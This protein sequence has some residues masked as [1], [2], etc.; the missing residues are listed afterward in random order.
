[1]VFAV[2]LSGMCINDDVVTCHLFPASMLTV[3]G[4]TWL[5]LE[6]VNNCNNEDYRT[7]EKQYAEL[8]NGKGEIMN[9]L[10]TAMNSKTETAQLLA[11]EL[12]DFTG[13]DNPAT[14]TP[15]SLLKAIR[16]AKAQ[17]RAVTVNRQIDMAG[18]DYKEEKEKFLANISRSNS[19]HTRRAYSAAIGRLEAWT[20]SEGI[21]PLDVDP[22]KADDFVYSMVK[23]EYS[24]ATIR[25]T[26]NAVSSFFNF[27]T[28]RHSKVII[29]PFRGSKALPKRKS[30]RPLVIPTADDYKVIVEELPPVEK[31]IVTTMAMRGLRA[32]ALP[33]LVIQGNRFTAY[34]K[35]DDIKGKLPAEAL[36][37]IKDAGLDVKKPFACY[38]VNTIEKK[39]NQRIGG[40]YRAGRI[41]A[42]YS[43]HDFRHFFAMN[44]YQRDKD[45]KKVQIML[46]HKNIAITDAYLRGLDAEITE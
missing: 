39:I 3:M 35:G 15:E 2:V 19:A 20:G 32:G 44:E 18:I 43:C 16:D 4:N 1:M 36:K 34:S 13:I 33:T 26:K 31:A 8:K 38:T 46:G 29:N 41:A 21:S 22:M 37:A 42:A 9:E 6:F 17:R 45:I 28:R 11:A 25:I 23:D 14:W 7:S 5:Y 27:L 10:V 30:V 24:P 40:L 12:A